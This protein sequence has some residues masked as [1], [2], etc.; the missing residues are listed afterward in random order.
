MAREYHESYQQIF[1]FIEMHR[2]RMVNGVWDEA[3]LTLE[4]TP[5]V[6]FVSVARIAHLAQLL[7][8]MW[9]NNTVMIGDK[10]NNNKTKQKQQKLKKLQKSGKVEWHQLL[11]F[12][13]IQ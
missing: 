1:K 6:I 10:K 9:N 2:L 5:F 11:Y 8:D 13:I 7:G 12:I 3:I 4:S